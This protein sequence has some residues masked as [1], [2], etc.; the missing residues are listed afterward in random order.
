MYL[1]LLEE[2]EMSQKLYYE[3]LEQKIAQL[4]AKLS[5]FT[6]LEGDA[7]ANNVSL[8][9]LFDVVPIPFYCKDINGIYRH[10]NDAFAETILGLDKDKIVGKSLYDF[11]SEIP[12]EKADI[13]HRKD[14]ELFKKAGRQSYETKVKCADGVVRYY[15]FYKLS[16][17]VD[18]EILG[19]FGIMLDISK[20]KNTLKELD[21]MNAALI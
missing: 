13:Y 14:A 5:L 17:V 20:Y 10:C 21:K 11:P 7:K 1:F 18:N 4:E 15:H 12:K 19:L 3:T 8:K 2:Q 9:E 6:S 16:F